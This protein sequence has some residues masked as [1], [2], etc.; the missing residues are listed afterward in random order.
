[1]YDF[2]KKEKR[3]ENDNERSMG[4]IRGTGKSLEEVAKE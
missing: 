1:M 4:E 3:E 2:R